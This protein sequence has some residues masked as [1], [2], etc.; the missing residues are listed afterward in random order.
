LLIT[1]TKRIL[2]CSKLLRREHTQASGWSMRPYEP[3]CPHT[4]LT[5]CDQMQGLARSWD[6]PKNVVQWRDD[7]LVYFSS[8]GII[9]QDSK[10]WGDP[11][12]VSFPFPQLTSKL[13]TS[14]LCHE[15]KY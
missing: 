12:E 1:R 7:W 11:R 15:I 2:R 8:T 14:A 10:I 9:W 6:Y 3:I 4:R 13:R 5:G